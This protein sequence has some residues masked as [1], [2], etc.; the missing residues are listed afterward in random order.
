MSFTHSYT[1]EGRAAMQVAWPTRSNFG[2]H[3]LAQGARRHLNLLSHS[4]PF[5]ETVW[6]QPYIS[7]S[8]CLYLLLSCLERPSLT[9]SS[10]C[11]SK[12]VSSFYDIPLWKDNNQ[13]CAA[14]S[15]PL[16]S[17]K[18]LP[19]LA[20]FLMMRAE[21]LLQSALLSKQSPAWP[22]PSWL[23]NMQPGVKPVFHGKRELEIHTEC[24]FTNTCGQIMSQ[25]KGHLLCCW[26]NRRH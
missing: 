25:S 17:L 11:F 24:T 5:C 12:P 1:D 7:V 9:P 6:T 8:I 4:R 20:P 18:S 3:C 2:I 21:C 15:L 14:H 10:F 23:V 26:Q 13:G 19:Q 16:R 22:P